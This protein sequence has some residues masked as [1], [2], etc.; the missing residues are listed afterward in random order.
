MITIIDGYTD[1]PSGLGVPPYLGT[2]PRY[3]YGYLKEKF[4]SEINYVTVDDLR[5]YL[6]G[7]PKRVQK[8]DISKLNLTNNFSSLGKILEKTKEMVIIAGVHTPGKYLSAR[9]ASLS[10]IIRL[11]RKFKCRKILTGPAVYG[12]ASEG[13]K[14]FEKADKSIFDEIKNFDFSYSDISKYSRIGSEIIKQIPD[15]RIVEIETAR[16][17]DRKKGCSFCT[18]PIKNRFECRSTAD[19]LSEIESFYDRG[20][21][22]FRLGKQSCFYSV[23]G[24]VRLLRD[25][26]KKFDDLRTLHI[27]NVNPAKVVS[28]SGEK[29]SR[30]I[31]EYCTPGNI[32]AFGVESFDSDV[33][34]QNNLNTDAETAFAAIEEINRIGREI[35]ENGM[36]KFLPGIN[37]LYGLKGESKKTH[38][39][40]MKWLT[41][42]VENDLLVRRINIRQ[43]NIFEGTPLYNSVGN[44]FLK[45]N[46]KYY[47]KW[48]NEIRQKIDYPLLKKLVPVGRV[49]KN[50]RME[51]HDGKHT[52]GRQL[53]SYPLI[54]GI[55][56]RIELGKFY[57]IKIKGHMLRSVTGELIQ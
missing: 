28:S 14:F 49:L 41:K 23:P 9:P 27:D 19:V 16:G 46:K 22:D 31:V 8:T 47:W 7:E 43:V 15:L 50:V 38:E 13:G 33:A 25:I 17:C 35:G 44:K 48:R 4:K 45:K 21:R 2:Y 54:V 55:N 30:A 20:I 12:S 37:L 26:N 56:E 34:T 40:N 51:V 1:E 18:E 6:S 3:I 39:E 36:P 57:K 24:V 5:K 42:V 52:F 11:V 29:I 32:A 53:G 10:E